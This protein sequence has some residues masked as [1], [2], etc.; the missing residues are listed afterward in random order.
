MDTNIVP[1]DSGKRR[2]AQ[3]LQQEIKE[4]AKQ[5][6]TEMQKDDRDPNLIVKLI[7]RI[8]TLGGRFIQITFALETHWWPTLTISEEVRKQGQRNVSKSRRL[9]TAKTRPP[10]FCEEISLT[11]IAKK[12]FF[13]PV[14][15]SLIAYPVKSYGKAFSITSDIIHEKFTLLPFERGKCFSYELYFLKC[16][17]WIGIIFIQKLYQGVRELLFLLDDR[18]KQKSGF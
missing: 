3:A 6:K 11:A 4:T 5:L 17:R 9:T 14:N 13:L 18:T 10:A 1:L 7:W 8:E 12:K 16:D 2:K 15:H